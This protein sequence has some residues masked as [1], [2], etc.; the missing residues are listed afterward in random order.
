MANSV[1]PGGQR[2]RATGSDTVH[3]GFCRLIAART[4]VPQP[5]ARS[6]IVPA[7]PAGGRSLQTSFQL[8]ALSFHSQFLAFSSE[9]SAFSV[10]SPAAFSSQL[11]DLRFCSPFQLSA[12]ALSFQLS[13]FRLKVLLTVQLAALCDCRGAYGRVSGSGF[14][15]KGSGSAVP[16][17]GSG[18][19]CRRSASATP[20][21]GR[22]RSAPARGFWRG[23]PLRG[24]GDRGR[25][26]RA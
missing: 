25:C 3:A 7:V 15:V 4:Q 18:L 16:G 24:S 12:S 14:R 6:H 10:R 9:P 22:V 5:V 20:G 11:S 23:S 17:P 21:A 1:H 13:V 2:G 8:S 26:R 19:S